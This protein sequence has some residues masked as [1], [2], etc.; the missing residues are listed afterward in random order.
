VAGELWRERTGALATFVDLFSR[1][2][3]D[4]FSV[5][6]GL[7]PNHIYILETKGPTDKSPGT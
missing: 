4:F 1:I 2:L 6:S 5:S 3:E 7:G